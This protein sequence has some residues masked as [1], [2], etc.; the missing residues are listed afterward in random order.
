MLAPAGL[1]EYR[2]VAQKMRDRVASALAAELLER[3]RK[4]EMLPDGEDLEALSLFL[5]RARPS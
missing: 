5:D 3:E 1:P 2:A 4:G